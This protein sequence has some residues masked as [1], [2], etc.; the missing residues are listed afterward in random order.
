MLYAL[1]VQ[2]AC[3]VS[4]FFSNL[5]LFVCNSGMIVQKCRKNLYICKKNTTFAPKCNKL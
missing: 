5:Q 2:F 3:K 4:V 1:C